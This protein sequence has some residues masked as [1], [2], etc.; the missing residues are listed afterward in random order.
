MSSLSLKHPRPP[1]K[2]LLS[3]HQSIKTSLKS[4]LPED[5]NTCDKVYNTIQSLVLRLHYITVDT[6]LFLRLY[7]LHL[8]HSQLPFPTI[9][10]EFVEDIFR[11]IGTKAPGGRPVEESRLPQ[12]KKL[13]DFYKNEFQPIYKHQ[14]HSLTNLH[15][16]YTYVSI[17]IVTSIETNIKTH[18]CKHL[19]KFI[20]IFGSLKYREEHEEVDEKELKTLL[21]KTKS[22][23]LGNKFDKVP[24]EF[25]YLLETIQSFLPKDIENS[26][27]YDVK[28]R[29][30][31]YLSSL[32]E[33]NWYFE[34][35]NDHTQFTN[36]EKNNK[37][38]KLFQPLPLRLSNVPKYVKIDTSTL[39]DLLEKEGKRSKLKSVKTIKK[40]YW[41][42]HFNLKHKVFK[43][44]ERYKFDY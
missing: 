2:K 29:P 19:V 13:E 26:I 32:F 17:S 24:E 35:Q 1:D 3:S 8:F 20:N 12:I 16:A 43:P 4:I 41:S 6:Y 21:C 44:K 18:F 34:I 40:G 37:L 23:I 38:I 25:K 27:P 7:F 39:I 42:E 36:K 11:A 14:K 5:L 30:Q 15:H 22:A 33:I 28:K 31:D 10:K 9:S